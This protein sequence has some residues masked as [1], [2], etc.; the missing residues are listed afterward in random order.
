MDR[1]AAALVI[2][3]LCWSAAAPAGGS[4]PGVLVNHDPAVPPTS[5]D[6]AASLPARLPRPFATADRLRLQD[7]ARQVVKHTYHESL[8][9][10]A[11]PLRPHGRA[12]HVGNSAFRTPERRPGSRY[13]VLP[14]RGRGTG[15]ATA[16]DIVLRRGARVVAPVTGK[17]VAVTPYRLYCQKPDTRVILKPKDR[18]DLRVVLFHVDRVHL[19]RGDRVDAGSSRI[20][21]VRFFAHSTA[22]YDAFVPGDHPHVHIE[23][24]RGRS[25]P[26]PG[27]R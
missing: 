5:A 19:R 21:R 25:F 24:H 22:Q 20:G 23:V 17:V 16:A 12:G 14:S 18:P 13:I 3:A 27:C 8:F 10:S 6:I 1:G 2:A 4:A 11:L 9:A 26:L 15:A 7:P